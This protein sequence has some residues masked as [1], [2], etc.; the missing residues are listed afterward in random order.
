MIA[1]R[2]RIGMGSSD[3]GSA[4]PSNDRPYLLPVGDRLGGC[5]SGQHEGAGCRPGPCYGLRLEE[6]RPGS[7]CSCP[8]LDR[9]D[10]VPEAGKAGG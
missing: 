7:R 8:R 9:L 2:L 6:A 5:P 4:D 3:L 1:L 10:D